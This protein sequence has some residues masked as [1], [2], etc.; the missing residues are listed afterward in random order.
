MGV[1]VLHLQ[2]NPGVG[3]PVILL[4]YAGILTPSL[5]WAVP[6]WNTA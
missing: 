4:N 5:L 2:A 6:N 1:P 3:L